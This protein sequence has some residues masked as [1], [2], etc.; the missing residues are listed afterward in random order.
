MFRT[1]ASMAK[2][3]D[4]EAEKLSKKKESDP[5]NWQVLLKVVRANLKKHH[6]SV[7]SLLKKEKYPMPDCKNKQL[8]KLQKGVD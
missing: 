8:T 3:L 7:A 5:K 6:V 2:G 1:I 4:Q